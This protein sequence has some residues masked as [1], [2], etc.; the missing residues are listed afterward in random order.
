MNPGH[1]FIDRPRFAVVISLL[2]VIIGLLSYFGLPVTQYPN[3]APPTIQVRATYPGASPE[4]ISKT[5]AT[6]LEQE[7]NGVDNMLYM[8][9]QSTSD[10]QMQ[11]TITF[12]AGT[13]LDIAQ[14]LVQNRIAVVEPR[15]P[16]EVRRLGVLVQKSSPD[17]MMVVHLQSP[18]KTFDNLYISN[19]AQLQIRDILARIEG[20]GNIVLFGAREFSMRIWLNPEKLNIYSLT[21]NDVV[22]SLQAQNVQVASGVLGQPPMPLDSAFQLTINSQGRFLDAEEFRNVIVKTGEDGRLLRLRDVARV[23]LG[24]RDYITNS[25]LNGK[26]AVAV[27]IFQR[28]G[29][30]ALETAEAVITTMKVLGK[31]F[32]Q[33]LASP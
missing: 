27:A 24:A 33:G 1:Y 6:P 3:I 2:I 28:P 20:V 23:E 12:T 8:P 4:I 14:V 7:V 32:P 13:D 31:S 29:S 26:P 19:Y 17:L 15:L 30:N 25:Y 9:S 5:V 22:Q 16:E 11:L 21:A 10:G 18:D